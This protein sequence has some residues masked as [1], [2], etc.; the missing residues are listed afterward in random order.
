M[1]YKLT[2]NLFF[3][4]NKPT[5]LLKQKVAH[6]LSKLDESIFIFLKNE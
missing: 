2:A 3:L 6:N 4:G 5:L 1:F